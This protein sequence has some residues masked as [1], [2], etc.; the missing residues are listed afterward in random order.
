MLRCSLSYA[1]VRQNIYRKED[2]FLLEILL[3]SRNILIYQYCFRYNIDKRN[4][5]GT[6]KYRN[7]KMKG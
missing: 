2:Y 3:I 1:K 6:T 4:K 5:L 7:P